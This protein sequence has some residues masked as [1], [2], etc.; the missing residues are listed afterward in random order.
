[1]GGIRRYWREAI[2]VELPAV[3][4]GATV[5]YHRETE[6]LL[7]AERGFLR[8]AYRLAWCDDAVQTEIRQQVHKRCQNQTHR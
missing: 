2:P 5:R 3:D 7:I 8:G 1:M 4:S 6:T